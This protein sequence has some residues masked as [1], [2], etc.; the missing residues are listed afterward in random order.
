MSGWKQSILRLSMKYKVPR[1]GKISTAGPQLTSSLWWLKLRV[2]MYWVLMQGQQGL[3]SPTGP[4]KHMG[5]DTCSQRSLRG[6]MHTLNYTLH[7]PFPG[8]RTSTQGGNYSNAK[9]FGRNVCSLRHNP[10]VHR[11]NWEN[12]KQR[13]DKKVTPQRRKGL[14]TYT[15]HNQHC[16]ITHKEQ[17]HTTAKGALPG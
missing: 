9:W 2:L 6:Q 3:A 8:E 16:S 14:I 10:K 12:N 5:T 7:T 4:W 17:L 13:Y 1:V 15:A 11:E